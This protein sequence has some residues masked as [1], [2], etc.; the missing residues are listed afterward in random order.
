MHP[1]LPRPDR[2]SVALAGEHR[3][4]LTRL[5]AAKPPGAGPSAWGSMDWFKSGRMHVGSMLFTEVIII[6]DCYCQD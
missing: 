5:A 4:L 3:A 1:L 2:S 6:F